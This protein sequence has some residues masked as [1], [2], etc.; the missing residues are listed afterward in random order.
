M[1]KNDVKKRAFPHL[2]IA[3]LSFVYLPLIVWLIYNSFLLWPRAKAAPFDEGFSQ[4]FFFLINKTLAMPEIAFAAAITLGQA[5]RNCVM[6]A[7]KSNGTQWQGA[8]GCAS[9]IIVFGLVPTLTILV[10]ALIGQ[11]EGQSRLWVTVAQLAFLLIGSVFFVKTSILAQ[12][13]ECLL[14]PQ[15][16]TEGNH[17]VENGA[18]TNATVV[19]SAVKNGPVTTVVSTGG[20]PA[21]AALAKQHYYGGAALV[22]ASHQGT[23]PVTFNKPL[24]EFKHPQEQ[25][26]IA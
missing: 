26:S 13:A 6:V 4:S 5:T 21:I 15:L 19:Y 24:S 20:N 7:G 2:V 3:E 18:A 23:V 22:K 17:S 1:G 16:N 10:L 9:Y 8:A 25:T 12:C 11:H 14:T